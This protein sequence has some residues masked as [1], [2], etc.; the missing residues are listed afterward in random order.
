MPPLREPNFEE[1]QVKRRLRSQNIP[2]QEAT[3]EPWFPW[4]HLGD[5]LEVICVLAFPR[6]R[7]IL[8]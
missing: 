6:S 7:A 1:K 4:A 2:V 8:V 3:R 5:M